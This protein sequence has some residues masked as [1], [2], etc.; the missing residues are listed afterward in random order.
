M[1][2]SDLDNIYIA[3]LRLGLGSHFRLRTGIPYTTN[4]RAHVTRLG[5]NQTTPF[6]T[7]P[8]DGERWET[9]MLRDGRGSPDAE[10]LAHALI[11]RFNSAL[12]PTR[13]GLACRTALL[14]TGQRGRPT[15]KR[16]VPTAGSAA[17][18]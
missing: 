14:L 13:N 17:D 4:Q 6:M 3:G 16:V 15:A 5:L 8:A 9:M 11:P 1:L 7:R 2:Y 10:E 18:I 12:G